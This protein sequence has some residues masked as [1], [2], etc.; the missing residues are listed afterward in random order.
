MKQSKR[1]AKKKQPFSD[2]NENCSKEKRRY[3]QHILLTTSN[4]LTKYLHIE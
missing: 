1:Y 2:M 4:P 3:E